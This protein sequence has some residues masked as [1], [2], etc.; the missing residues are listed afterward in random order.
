MHD[1][2]QS[3]DAPSERCVEKLVPHHRRVIGEGVQVPHVA[4]DQSAYVLHLRAQVLVGSICTQRSDPNRGDKHCDL[5]APTAAPHVSQQGVAL[6]EWCHNTPSTVG[7]S[8]H[9]LIYF[10]IF[11]LN[12]PRVHLW[13]E[14]HAS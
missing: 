6:E 11:F 4:V 5:S 13:S 1:T 2:K 10:C 9:H 7:V 12:Y 14:L 3:D 8:V